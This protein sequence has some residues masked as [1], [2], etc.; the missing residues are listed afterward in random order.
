[1]CSFLLLLIMCTSTQPPPLCNIIICIIWHVI[2]K[3]N[4]YQDWD[5]QI[6]CNT[7]EKIIKKIK[8]IVC[9]CLLSEGPTDGLGLQE[10]QEPWE[11]VGP[12]VPHGHDVSDHY[13]PH[14]GQGQVL[15]SHSKK[16]KQRWL[17]DLA[18]DCSGSCRLADDRC[19]KLAL[20][21]DM[22][23]C[24]VGDIAPADNIS[25]AEKHRREE[26]SAKDDH[27]TWR[28]VLTVLNLIWFQEA[29]RR[30]AAL[31]PEGLQQE[32]YALWEVPCIPSGFSLINCGQSNTCGNIC[33]LFTGI[34]EPEQPRGPARQRIWPSGNDSPGSRVRG[35]RGD[36]RKTAGFL[37]LHQWWLWMWSFLFMAILCKDGTTLLLGLKDVS[38]SHT[39]LFQSRSPPCVCSVSG[40]FHHPDVLQ[41]LGSLSELRE[42]HMA[43]M[44]NS[45]NTETEGPHADQW[46]HS[47]WLRRRRCWT[48]KWCRQLDR[49]AE[50]HRRVLLRRHRSASC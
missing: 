23:E 38:S 30:L 18:L 26:A 46:C 44:E 43:R 47:S 48:V 12:Y 35:T 3:T 2:Y 11:C 10:C 28:T 13:W 36:T 8:K 37:W 14:C 27:M 45:A 33:T 50:S 32:I 24:I 40:C 22:A 15:H 17:I 6:L 49:R 29:M 5:L 21:H 4:Y 16:T 7:L 34:W 19:I 31:L 9:C 20:V 39:C 25:K 42:R 1:M 41:L